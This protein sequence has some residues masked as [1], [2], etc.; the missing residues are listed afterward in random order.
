MI[1]YGLLVP[2]YF[3]GCICINIIFCRNR[4]RLVF[5]ESDIVVEDIIV[6]AEGIGIVAI[7]AALFEFSGIFPKCYT[8]IVPSIP[9][10]VLI[11]VTTATAI[12]NNEM[13]LPSLVSQ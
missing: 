4:L 9:P 1:Q 13:T 7:D 11:P 6:L 12:L 2:L 3:V 10:P 8:C 5:I